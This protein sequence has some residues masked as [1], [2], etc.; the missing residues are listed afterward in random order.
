MQ[1]EGVDKDLTHV[2]AHSLRISHREVSE[3]IEQALRNTD[4]AI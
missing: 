3:G 1:Y 4:V 2:P